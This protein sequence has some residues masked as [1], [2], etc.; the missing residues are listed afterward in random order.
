MS[1]L[2]KCLRHLTDKKKP[3]PLV[4]GIENRPRGKCVT[5]KTSWAAL[6]GAWAHRGLEA[7][8]HLSLP[9][10]LTLN[11][12][13]WISEPRPLCRARAGRSSQ[14][15]RHQYSRLGLLVAL[16]APELGLGLAV[17]RKEAAAWGGSWLQLTKSTCFLATLPPKSA[18]ASKGQTGT[19]RGQGR[20]WVQGK[21]GPDLT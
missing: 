18:E 13:G 11:K 6:C 20:S 8:V 12:A 1:K 9:R 14:R 15:Q 7:S 10:V 2:T 5:S 4:N 3:W 19:C 17:Y 21:I 16:G